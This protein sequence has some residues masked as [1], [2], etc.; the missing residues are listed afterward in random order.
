MVR[1]LL[2]DPSSRGG[3][4]AYTALIAQAVQ[5]AGGEPTVLG[6][7]AL[8]AATDSVPRQRRLPDQTWGR[9]DA[10]GPGFYARRLQAWLRSALVVAATVRRGQPDV[11]HFQAALNR[12]FDAFLLRRL[13][14]R[15]PVVGRPTTCFRSRA[16][17][18]IALASR[19]ST[20]QL[21]A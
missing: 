4:A 9:P 20:G 10:I 19:R 1:V 11:V 18:P 12:R 2:I 15:R 7:R 21:T 16:P 17:S 3:I 6:A 5:S 8:E 14:P 13:S